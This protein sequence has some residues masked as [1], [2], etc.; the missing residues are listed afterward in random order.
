MR[1]FYYNIILATTKHP[2]SLQE[3]MAVHLR[4]NRM[5]PRQRAIEV[6]QVVEPGWLLYST[7]QQDTI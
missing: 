1:K 3:A 4:D 5:G 7:H 6:E 2:R